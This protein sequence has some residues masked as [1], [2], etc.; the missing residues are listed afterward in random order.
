MGWGET[1]C[2]A[3]ASLSYIGIKVHFLAE[4]GVVPLGQHGCL[5]KGTLA[6]PVE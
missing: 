5:I 3:P 1:S 6:A 2:E 4:M